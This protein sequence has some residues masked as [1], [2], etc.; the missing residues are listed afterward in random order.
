MFS[1]NLQ[2]V[3]QRRATAA[4]G[5]MK[6]REAAWGRHTASSAATE[7]CHNDDS[8]PTD[9]PVLST[10]LLNKRPEAVGFQWVTTVTK[11]VT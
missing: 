8:G 7:Q 9:D 6:R 10:G 2:I 5:A 4:C 3:A 11:T 1:P